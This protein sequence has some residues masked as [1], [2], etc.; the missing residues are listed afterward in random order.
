MTGAE[1]KAA[2]E[3]LGLTAE[4][5]A[6]LMGYSRGRATIYDIEARAEI[7]GPPAKV[8]EAL[9]DGWR[10]SLDHKAQEGVK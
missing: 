2:R 4:T 8:M 6:T 3:H 9:L 1:F 7:V 10:P 5:L